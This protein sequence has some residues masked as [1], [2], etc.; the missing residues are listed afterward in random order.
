M[1]VTF[2]CHTV[3]F[4]VMWTLHNSMTY[5]LFVFAIAC[6]EN[7]NLN[8]RNI[9]CLLFWDK[10][11][12]LFQ[13]ERKCHSLPVINSI[14]FV[15][16]LLNNS[17]MSPTFY[18]SFSYICIITCTNV[19]VAHFLET[20]QCQIGWDMVCQGSI[21]LLTPYL[22]ENW[23]TSLLTMTD[24]LTLYWSYDAP[25]DHLPTINNWACHSLPVDYGTRLLI[26][27]GSVTHKLLSWDNISYL[28][29][30]NV[31]YPLVS[32]TSAPLAK[33]VVTTVTCISLSCW[34][35]IWCMTNLV[36]TWG[37]CCVTYN[38]AIFCKCLSFHM[39]T[40]YLPAHLLPLIF[41]PDVE[42]DKNTYPEMWKFWKNYENDIIP[43]PIC[44]FQNMSETMSMLVSDIWMWPS[45]P[46][47]RFNTK[48]K[49]IHLCWNKQ[50][51]YA[52]IIYCISSL[53]S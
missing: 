53:L 21:V 15:E 19:N 35:A 40:S 43:C 7:F 3:V 8:R 38:L 25:C 2:C 16:T 24:Q 9:Y 50:L 47:S 12:C 11:K 34:L 6:E 20:C 27:K 29:Y 37:H 13:T 44:I 31:T 10:M 28:C 23:L 4:H 22:S 42:F 1:P 41:C 32:I 36:F 46:K 18:C 39:K 14:N 30:S 5:I 45:A 48:V 49:I 26:T 17:V 52:V 51:M 33:N